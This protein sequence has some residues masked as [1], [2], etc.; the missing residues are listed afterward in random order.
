MSQ[1]FVVF[2]PEARPAEVFGPFTSG[3]VATRWAGRY[4]DGLP[5]T[6]WFWA[7]E[8][9]ED[10]AEFATAKRFHANLDILK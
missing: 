4:L 8:T 10:F 2:Q 1:I 9:D 6:C 3:E 5:S 7:E